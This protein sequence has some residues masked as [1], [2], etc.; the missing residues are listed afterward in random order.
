VNFEGDGE[1]EEEDES[2][3]ASTSTTT[4]KSKPGKSNTA[5]ASKVAGR[6]KAAPTPVSAVPIR[7]SL[8]LIVE[9]SDAELD[10]VGSARTL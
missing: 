8:M 9:E 6:N 10:E 7:S 3:D 5:T 2:S 1:I 4:R